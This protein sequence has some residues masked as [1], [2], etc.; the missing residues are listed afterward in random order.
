MSDPMPHGT[1]LEKA[2]WFCDNQKDYMWTMYQLET[3]GVLL[4]QRL[5]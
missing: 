2:I 4:G 1:W 5:D 3:L